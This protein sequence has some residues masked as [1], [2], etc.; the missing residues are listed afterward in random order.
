MVSL[1]TI[2]RADEP[3]IRHSFFVAGQE[4]YIVDEDGKV[5]WTYPAGTRDGYVL[6]DGHILM[7][8]SKNKQ[9]P[10]GAVVE[11]TPDNK[12]VF[13]YKGTQGETHAVEPLES[14]NILTVEGGAMP[15]LME[16]T[17]EGKVAVEFP[18]QCQVPNVHMQTRM[19][20]KLADGTYLVPHLLD[21]AVKQ[22]DATGKVLAVIDTTA[23]GD[24]QHKIETWPFTAIRLANGHTLCGLTHSDRVAEFDAEGKIV[25]QL[26]NED[27]PEPLIHDACGVQRLPNGNTVIAPY[28]SRTPGAVKL[29]EVTPEKK[30]VWTYKDDKKHG[31]HDFQILTTNGQQLPWPPLK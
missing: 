31:I 30:V 20:R 15:K 16:L 29:F 3:A 13:E 2:S 23:P 28:A 4:T 25:W 18:L 8:V 7:A 1:V 19:A 22:Y 14:G 21:F 11:V 17:R 12:V 6:P 10:G 5:T 24:T 27:L 9:Y 26:T